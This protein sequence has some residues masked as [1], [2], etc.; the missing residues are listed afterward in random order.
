MAKKLPIRPVISKKPH[1]NV[2]DYWDVERQL[3]AKCAGFDIHFWDSITQTKVRRRIK[4]D[5]DAAKLAYK[6]MQQV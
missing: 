3:W 1:K 5:Y 6:E 2:Y 4:A